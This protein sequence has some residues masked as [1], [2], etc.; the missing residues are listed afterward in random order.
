MSGL[1]SYLGR[2]TDAWH[3]AAIH[4][5]RGPPRAA[6]VQHAE[7]NRVHESPREST[8]FTGC[9]L[10]KHKNPQVSEYR[11]ERTSNP[12]VGGSN[13]SGRASKCRGPGDA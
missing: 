3:V 7:G 4:R 9:D 10:R 2:G 1:V 5:T 12:R 11:L 8:R 6:N 13:P